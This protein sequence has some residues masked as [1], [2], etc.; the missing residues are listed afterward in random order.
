[1]P[2]LSAFLTLSYFLDLVRGTITKKRSETNVLTFSDVLKSIDYDI[3][4]NQFISD[5]M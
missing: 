1:M 2:H 4:W 5:I 3:S